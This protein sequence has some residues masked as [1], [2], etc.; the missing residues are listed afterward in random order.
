MRKPSM[1]LE[2]GSD[3]VRGEGASDEA[4]LI[5]LRALLPEDEQFLYE[6][7][8][9]TRSH[10]LAHIPWDQAQL[11]A[12]LKMQL[13]ARDQSYRMHYTGIDD[14]IILFKGQPVGR[15]ILVRRD[16]EIRLADVALLSEHRGKGIGSALIKDLMNEANSSA[17]PIRL[18]VDKPNVGA[19]RLYERLG[20]SVT[21]ENMTHFQMEYRPGA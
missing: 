3:E 10:E 13:K 6:V 7:Y 19:L 14:S 11:N 16:E 9:S 1:S 8:A 21:G 18:Q 2:A 5:T 4:Q 17:R 15:L 12:F 20:F